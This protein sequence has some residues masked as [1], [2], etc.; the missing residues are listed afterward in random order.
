M[1]K[2]IESSSNNF[3]F[4]V[5]RAESISETDFQGALK[6]ELL[7]FY[8]NDDKFE[9]LNHFYNL[10]DKGYKE[11]LPKCT[12]PPICPT[13]KAFE[14]ALYFTQQECDYLTDKIVND[15]RQRDVGTYIETINISGANSFVNIG[16][17]KDTIIN[18]SQQLQSRGHK[19]ISENI[20]EL[21][22]SIEEAVDIPDSEKEEL[23]D[24]VKFL[25]EQAL[26]EESKRNN[27]G[28]L[29]NV[30]KGIFDSLNALSAI[31]TITDKNLKDIT[32]FF[33]N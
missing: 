16:K 24:N 29:R 19:G 18:N 10:V 32:D 13:N 33:L 8:S 21:T 22:E 3:Y 26:L 6:K 11:H 17:I 14:N 27:K 7:R 1:N 31:S 30:I 23:L 28:V 2:V 25:S 4:Q 5:F 9:Y 12:N 15:K 20:Q